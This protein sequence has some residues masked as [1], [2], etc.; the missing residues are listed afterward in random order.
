MGDFAVMGLG[1]K[2]DGGG[3]GDGGGMIMNFEVSAPAPTAKKSRMN[4]KAQ[5]VKKHARAEAVRSLHRHAMY[6]PP[7]CLLPVSACTDTHSR[8]R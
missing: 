2:G 5:S 8:L 4:V 6:Q 1:H 7:E 3:D